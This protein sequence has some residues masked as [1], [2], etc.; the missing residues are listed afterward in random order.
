MTNKSLLEEDVDDLYE[1]A[2]CGYISALPDGTIVKANTTF[3]NWTGYRLDEIVDR[4]RFQDLLPVPGRIFHDT[5]YTPLLHMQGYTKEL[6]FEVICEGGRR[7][8]VLLNSTLKRDD[9]GNP[10]LIRTTLLDARG[11]RAYEQELLA[12]RRKAEEAEAAVRRL[13]ESLEERVSARTAER[14]RLWGISQDMLVIASLD[15]YFLNCNPAFTTT[16]GWTREDM[17][18]IRFAE[19]ADPAQ[20]DELNAMLT[21]LAVGQPLNRYKVRSRCKDGTYRWLS[22][23]IVPEGRLLYMVGR[24][25]TDERKQ[26]EALRHAEDALRQA[27]KMEAVG[28]LTGGLAH[29]FNNLLA[30][31]VGN[32]QMMRVRLQ[33]G[34]H[35]DLARYIDSAESIADRAATLTHRLLAF[36][37]RQTLDPKVVNVNRLVASMRDMIERTVGPAIQVSTMLSDHVWN[38]RCDANQLDNALLN[39]VINARDAMPHGGRLRIET[40]NTVVDH[41]DTAVG[42]EVKPGKY[43]AIIVADTGTGMKPEVLARAFD[44]FFTTKPIG[45][46]TGLGLSMAFG[47]A[48]QSGGFVRIHSHP[49]QGTKVCIYLPMHA[50]ETEPD[51]ADSAQ[52]G[53]P[54][55]DA[56]A[57]ILLVDDE[58]PLREL[59]AELL[60]GLGYTIIEAEDGHGGLE[61]LKSSRHID[62]LVTD[63]GLP[64]GMNGREL[65]L[66]AR[67]LRPGLEV[68][69]IT[70]YAQDAA[71][72]KS[73][74]EPGMHVMTKPFALDAFAETVAGAVKRRERADE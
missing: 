8:P 70:G 62:L 23:T 66:A 40:D 61:V 48:R 60:T 29:D 41:V 51:T 68:L 11:R 15:G 34:R 10:L 32:L 44:P 7:I 6:A 47:F 57:A 17:E 72:G 39:L 69:F 49:G 46:G 13:N 65:A 14:D 19:L 71:F 67:T 27:Q 45:Q 38:T 24:D 3:L 56:G 54:Q 26:A 21:K 31:I 30:G 64:G 16:M 52:G 58:A 53:A 73:L 37:R 55:A 4:K 18:S 12:A 35:G 28:Q 59:L 74:A 20:A 5:H 36:S 25:V 22:W 9:N 33:Q 42:E 63:V 43:V 1:N 2:P 50:G